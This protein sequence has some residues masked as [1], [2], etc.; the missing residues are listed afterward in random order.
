[1]AYLSSRKRHLSMCHLVMILPFP[2]LPQCGHRKVF[3]FAVIRMDIFFRVSSD[4]FWSRFASAIFCTTSGDRDLPRI[5]LPY[6][7]R[8]ALT[9]DD[10][11]RA[12]ERF[13]RWSSGIPLE[14]RFFWDIESF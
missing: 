4:R 1:M 2:S 6:F 13:W 12:F 3:I 14:N 5:S 8:A 7:W 10:D 11:L 9:L